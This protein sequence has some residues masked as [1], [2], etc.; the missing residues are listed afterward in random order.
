[1]SN[2][3]PANRVIILVEH[4]FDEATTFYLLKRLR[5]AQIK[6]SLVGPPSELVTGH[7]GVSVRPDFSFGDLLLEEA[8]PL[9]ILPG[10]PESVYR[11]LQERD[12]RLWIRF[13]L[14]G[15]YVAATE[16]AEIALTGFTFPDWETN[17][18][19]QGALSL[20]A[21]S[22]LLIDYAWS[23]ARQEVY[24]KDTAPYRPFSTAIYI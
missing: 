19:A 7:W 24:H 21:F 1:M 10:Q 12:I 2:I 4:G 11:L 14:E 20:S 8:C 13:V 15:N 16:T 22:Q 5:R 3:S 18:L 6:V 23:K 17:Y 9:L